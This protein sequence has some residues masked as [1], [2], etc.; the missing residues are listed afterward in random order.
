[1][2][3]EVPTLA[4][5]IVEIEVNTSCL[6]DDFL[7]HRIGLV[8]LRYKGDMKEISFQ[9]ECTCDT[10]GHCPNCT[11]EL[12]L[13]EQCAAGGDEEQGTDA[14]AV[15]SNHLK[16]TTERVKAA[17]EELGYEILA[18]QDASIRLAK[19]RAGQEIK[20]K[21]L[22]VKGTG[23]EHTKWSPVA[24]AVY[25]FDPI[26]RL[27][28]EKLKA[29]SGEQKAQLCQSCPANVFKVDDATQDIEVAHEKACMFCDECVKVGETFKMHSLDDNVVSVSHEPRRF[30]FSVETTGSLDP[31]KVVQEA[32]IVLEDKV[33]DFADK[34][35][36][37]AESATN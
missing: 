22:A 18:H 32:L 16:D 20:L 33:R 15:T 7:A 10:S 1:M 28:E 37:I 34:C 8:P 25:A 4:V 3:A 23:Q 11:V 35:V 27:N 13:H 5:D 12:V 19:L 17:Q 21:A 30:I 26:V 9:R 31:G 29:L 2:I 24:T 6:H 36:V 14:M